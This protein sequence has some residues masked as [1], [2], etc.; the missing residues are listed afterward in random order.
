MMAEQLDTSWLA[1]A[2][3]R[4]V[5]ID[6]FFPPVSWDND[7]IH[8]GTYDAAEAYCSSCPVR[9]ECLEAAIYRLEYGMWGGTSERGRARMRRSLNIVATVIDLDD[10]LFADRERE[11][12]A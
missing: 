10:V 12:A 3:C 8:Q 11:P 6:V 4:G 1:Q 2:R 9:Q 7:E 5:S